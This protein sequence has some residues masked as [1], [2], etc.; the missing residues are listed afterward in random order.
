MQMTTKALAC[1]PLAIVGLWGCQAPTK[2][3]TSCKADKDCNLQQQL[4]VSGVSGGPKICTHTCQGEYGDVGCPIGFDCNISDQAIGPTCNKTRYSVDATTG[5]ALLFGKSCATD[6]SLCMNTGDPAGSPHCRKGP[7]YSKKP[8]APLAA[9]PSA[10]C[11]GSCTADT[12]CPINMQCGEDYDMQ[13]KCLKRTICS[14]CLFNDN[15]PSVYPNCVATA[16][17][18][19]HY[20]TK[21]CNSANDCPGA[22]QELIWAACNGGTDTSGLAAGFC[23]PKAGACVGAGQICDL[24]RTDA[25]CAA[26]GSSCVQN[27]QTAERFCS[28]MCTSDAMCTG[29][30]KKASCDTNFYGLCTGDVT[31]SLSSPAL[32]CW[33]F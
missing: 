26:S 5:A 9:D 2:I 23:Q 7:D 33:G 27:P 29:G 31:H 10:Y 21:T 18:K 4:C 19:S 3:G 16:D 30:A 15:C 25:D 6:D 13:K 8:V 1:L 24:C 17:G 11:T 32:S 14:E 28:K 20:C 12:D 22:P